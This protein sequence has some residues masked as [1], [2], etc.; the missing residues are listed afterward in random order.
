MIDAVCT[1]V[2]A[3]CVVRTL[4]SLYFE[5]DVEKVADF[6][7]SFAIQRHHVR[8]CMRTERC[9]ACNS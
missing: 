5:T 8:V 7:S 3:D 2:I 1:C 4:G 9:S 6:L